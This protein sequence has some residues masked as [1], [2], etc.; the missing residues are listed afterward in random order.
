MQLTAADIVGKKLRAISDLPVQAIPG[1]G[2]AVWTLLPTGSEFT[3]QTWVERDGQVWWGFFLPGPNAGSGT[4]RYYYV[5][6][7]SGYFDKDFINDQL[8]AEQPPA[9]PSAGG[10]PGWAVLAGVLYGGFNAASSK[11]I[12]GRYLWGLGTAGLVGWYGWKLLSNI[13]INPFD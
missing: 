2:E 5:E 3:V 1:A 11:S 8:A 12:A 7:R 4:E 13:D 10:L 6:H 9:I